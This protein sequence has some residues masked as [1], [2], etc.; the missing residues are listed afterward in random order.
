MPG[1]RIP[2]PG[3]EGG[4]CVE[5]HH[6]ECREL[7]DDAAEICPECGDPCGFDRLLFERWRDRRRVHAN[8][9]AR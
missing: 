6:R 2:R 3:T 9:E 5:C 7:R 8:C 4:P 1:V